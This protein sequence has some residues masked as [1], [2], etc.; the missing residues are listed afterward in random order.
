MI[1]TKSLDRTPFIK[2]NDCACESY[3]PQEG[4][5]RN[6]LLRA[7]FER[8]MHLYYIYICICLARVNQ[9]NHSEIP[10]QLLF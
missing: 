10:L 9:A 6:L 5:I 1:G 4:R 8:S 3:L 7:T 2:K